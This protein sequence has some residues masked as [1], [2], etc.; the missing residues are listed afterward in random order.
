MRKKSIFSKRKKYI[1]Y[2]VVIVILPWPSG[3]PFFLFIL[4]LYILLYVYACSVRIMFVH[5]VQC[6]VPDQLWVVV[7]LHVGVDN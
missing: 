5:P 6:L 1:P 2:D 7:S 4:D 3:I